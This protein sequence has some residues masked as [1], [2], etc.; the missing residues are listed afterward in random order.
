MR[1]IS[2]KLEVE[3][4]KDLPA[5]VIVKALEIATILDDNYGMNRTEKDLGGYILIAEVPEDVETIKKLIDFSYTVPEYVDLI[6]CSNG[7]IYSSSL[8]LIS[9]DFSISLIV[10]FFITPK[11]LLKHFRN[12]H[13]Y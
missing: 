5:E 9:S 1:K 6:I 2:H 3:A 10:P 11:K 8:I 4:L 7:E 13:E 12:S